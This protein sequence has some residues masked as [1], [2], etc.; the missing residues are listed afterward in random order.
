MSNEEIKHIL[1]LHKQ[2][3]S[4]DPS[5]VRANLSGFDL[6]GIDFEDFDLRGANLINVN[7][8]GANLGYVNFGGAH[9]TNANF[10][11]ACLRSANFS[12]AILYNAT[13]GGTDL[14]NANFRYAGLEEANFIESDLRYTNFIGACLRCADFRGSNLRHCIG[15]GREIVTITAQWA[16]VIYNTMMAVG[17]EAHEIEEW[18]N[19]DETTIDAMNSSA[20]VWWGAW[21][22]IIFKLIDEG[23]KQ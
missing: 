9:L 7:F 10:D 20:V 14:T 8:G 22:P 1:N 5:G 2:Y 12:G 16:I 23:F 3:V 6:S 4:G 17:C 19:F 18:R 11:G 21:K 13:F 15:N